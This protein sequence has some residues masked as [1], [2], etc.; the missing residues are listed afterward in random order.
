[1]GNF[2][3]ISTETIGSKEYIKTGPNGIMKI[4][5]SMIKRQ[6]QHAKKKMQTETH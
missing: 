1:M 6:R 3:G 4:I 5:I 2:L